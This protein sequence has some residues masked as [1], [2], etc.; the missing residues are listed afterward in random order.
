MENSLG[1][2]TLYNYVNK[3]YA[4]ILVFIQSFGYKA[5]IGVWS[6]QIC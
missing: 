1:K 2:N 4:K 3:I 5:F 6:D